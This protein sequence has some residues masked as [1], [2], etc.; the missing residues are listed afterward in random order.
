MPSVSLSDLIRT[1]CAGSPDHRYATA[2]CTPT[3]GMR[4]RAWPTTTKRSFVQRI[5]FEF[6]FNASRDAYMYEKKSR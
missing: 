6:D 4:L 3:S 2:K 5:S 1:D